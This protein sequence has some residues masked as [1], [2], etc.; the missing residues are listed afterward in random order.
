MKIHQ[1]LLTNNNC[2][3]TGKKMKPAGIMVHS[4]GANNPK[5][6]RYVQ[7]DDGILGVNKHNTHWN[8]PKP[9]G[10][11]VCVH[12]FIGKDKNNKVQVYQT[13]PW[14]HIGWHSG[15]GRN[16]SAN[17][18]GYIGF[19]ICEDDLKDK[20]YLEEAYNLAVEL[21]AYLC[22][23]YKID[24]NK[25]I[26]HYEGHQ[27][28]I[29]S[30]H[31]D[32]RHWFN[33]HGKSMDGLRKDVKAKLNPP[34]KQSS[35]TNLYRVRKSWPDSKSQL[36]AFSVLQNAID[37]ATKNKD[38]KV[39]NE[40]G[41]QVYPKTETKPK[42]T[43]TSYLVKVTASALNIRKGPGTNYKING[44]IRD[45]GTY[46]IVDTNGKWGKLKSGAGWIHLDYTKKI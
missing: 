5:L 17:T 26:G 42:A 28:G 30:N 23:E 1:C 3:K 38:Y 33:K 36:G 2:Y 15:S 7:P 39:F 16:G 21:C 43:N 35:P 37:L 45:K 6:S 22:K 9:G 18:L 40:Q 31:A 46:T 4:T 11:S 27:Q 14:D 34:K 44:V 19:E 29:A 13:L 8:Q 20:K 12:A 41:E 25:I 32:P 10:R 24:T